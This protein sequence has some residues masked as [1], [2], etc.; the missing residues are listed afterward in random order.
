MTQHIFQV[1]AACPQAVEQRIPTA[2]YGTPADTDWPKTWGVVTVSIVDFEPKSVTSVPPSMTDSAGP[3]VSAMFAHCLNRSEF[4]RS[5]RRWA[6]LTGSGSV[7]T[8]NV[9]DDRPND[10]AAFPDCV[11]GDLTMKAAN[12]LAIE[13]NRPR[14]KLARIPREWSIPVRKFTAEGGLL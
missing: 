9:V 11:Q 12:E 7:L 5:R 4:Y 14:L 13:L 6:L 3:H 2:N 1:V 8:V 10:P